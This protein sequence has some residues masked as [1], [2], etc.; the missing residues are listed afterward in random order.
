MADPLFELYFA[1]G[2]NMN[3]EQMRVRCP[4]SQ[5]QG[6]ARLVGYEFYMTLLQK[7]IIKTA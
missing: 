1:Y 6:I 3:E 5:M 4:D 2:S 7:V